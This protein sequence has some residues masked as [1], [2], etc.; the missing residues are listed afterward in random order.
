[1]VLGLK[2]IL[3]ALL[4]TTAVMVPA[5]ANAAEDRYAVDRVYKG[6]ISCKGDPSTWC[7]GAVFKQ[8]SGCGSN[9]YGC[10]YK[11]GHYWQLR[12]TVKGPYNSA[13]Q[14]NCIAS[15][16]LLIGGLYFTGPLVLVIAGTVVTVWGCSL[17]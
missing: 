1:M 10:F 17:Q 9:S 7:W 8:V 15:L 16:A 2:H 13:A 6:Y 4:I 14:A 11:S 12:N 3:A 5:S